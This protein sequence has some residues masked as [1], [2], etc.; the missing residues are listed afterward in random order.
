MER[1]YMAFD[2]A[3]PNEERDK[4]DCILFEAGCK[5][6]EDLKEENGIS[7]IRVYFDGETDFN[8]QASPLKDYL[9]GSFRI[10][11][12]NWNENWKK[13]FKPTPIG[14]KV[15]VV[16]SW[17]KDDFDPGD[18]IPIYIYPGQTF[19]TG[20]HETTKLMMEL[21]EEFMLPGFSFL[22][23]G[24]GTGILSILAK[25]LGAKRVVACDI[26]KEVEDELELNMTINNVS[27]IEF[28]PGSVDAVEG[29]FD[30]VA[31]NIE[32]HLLEPLIPD[33]VKRTGRYLLVSGILKHQEEDMVNKLKDEGLVIN[34][35][36]REG[37]WIAIAA[38]K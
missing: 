28:I 21:I 17:M 6:I 7:Y 18:R 29:T 24:C 11:E 12:Q 36:R 15:V 30:M 23:V 10:E 5:G 3:I 38:M 16:P 8:P 34:E 22:D 31:A 1:Y 4:A 33:L 35:I 14:K 37:E 32:K 27:G 25:K 20:T 19:G 26:Q 2:F 13:H 9:L